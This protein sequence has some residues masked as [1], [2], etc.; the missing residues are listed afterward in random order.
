ME[1]FLEDIGTEVEINPTINTNFCQCIYVITRHFRSR[2]YHV[3]FPRV[4]PIGLWGVRYSLFIGINNSVINNS[5]L[6][7]WNLSKNLSC[8]SQSSVFK[9]EILFS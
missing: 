4:F 8:S 6:P 5:K 2:D 1:D 3:T 7:L 9:F